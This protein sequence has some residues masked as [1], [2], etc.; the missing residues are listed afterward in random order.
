MAD[1]RFD[2]G[3]LGKVERT[4]QGGARVPAA[5]T[6]TGVF[7]YRNADGSLRREYRPAEEVFRADSLATLRSAPVTD[8]AHVWVDGKNWRK[9]SCGHVAEGSARQDN[10]LLVSELV[11]Q[12]G[13]VLEA[14]DSGQRADISCGYTVDY[15]PTPGVFQGQPYDGVQRNIKYNHVTLLGAGQGRAGSRAGLRL[16]ANDAIQDDHPAGP[17][18]NKPGAT[19]KERPMKIR[20]DGKDYDLTKAD[21]AAAY[22][23][24]VSAK[25]AE[26]AK[27]TA[28]ADQAEA[29]LKKLR[30]DAEDTTRF[31]AAVTERVQL[32]DTA[33]KLL[34]AT[35]SATRTDSVNGVAVTV[36]KSNREVMIDVIRGD[37]KDFKDTDAAGKPRSDDYVRARYDAI[38]E[39]GVRADSITNLPGIVR[40][41]TA[42]IIPA[43]APGVRTDAAPV[44]SADASRARMIEGNRNAWQSKN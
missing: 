39:K 37:D 16:D 34:G 44:V 33:G 20:S 43:P 27:Q 22:Q 14:V 28:R 29:D 8:G 7:T 5:L 38:A 2:A 25:E 18:G 30:T 24:A 3:K 41:V 17:A 42:P 1:R 21:E 4:P 32:L 36:S 10:D 35:Y 12:D 31:D 15:D 23:A 13:D 19:G 11:I 40:S 9:V 6:R 26:L